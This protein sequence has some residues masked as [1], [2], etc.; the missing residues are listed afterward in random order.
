[1]TIEVAFQTALFARLNAAILTLGV[2]GVY[3]IAPQDSDS[4]DASKFP[5]ITMGRIFIPQSDTQSKNGFEATCR[6]HT[7]SR[8]G[9][10][11]ECK[12]IQGAIYGLLHNTPLTVTGFNNYLLLRDDTDCFHDGDTKIHGICEYRG[13]IETA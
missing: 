5:Y 3:D 2:E 10:M 6:I 9:S 1:M 4:G 12:G 11:L 8:S 13:L 7:F